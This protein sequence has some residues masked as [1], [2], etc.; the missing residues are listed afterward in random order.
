MPTSERGT[1]SRPVC[2]AP[3]QERTPRE[4]T[5]L[6]LGASVMAYGIRRTSLPP[7]TCTRTVA[8]T[9]CRPRNE[10]VDLPCC[11]AAILVSDATR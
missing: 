6:W 5:A 3:P 7:K 9:A 10:A 1:K 8:H 2:G 4:E 11:G